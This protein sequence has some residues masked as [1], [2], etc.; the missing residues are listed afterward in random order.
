MRTDEEKT[1]RLLRLVSL[2]IMWPAWS[3]AIVLMLWEGDH[4]L[5]VLLFG[6]IGILGSVL[7]FAA[8]RMSRGQAA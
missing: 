3:T 8:P 5:H 1:R 2:C 7:W 6:T 4:F